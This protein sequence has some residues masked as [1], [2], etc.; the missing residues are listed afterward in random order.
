LPGARAVASIDQLPLTGPG[1]SGT[2]TIAGDAQGA[3]HEVLV[4]SVSDRYFD[5]LGLAVTQGR[6]FEATDGPTSPRVVVV[7]RLLAD[8]IFG[9][10]AV[11]HRIAF[12]FFDGQPWWEIVGVVGNEQ[13][14]ALDRAMQPVVYFPYAQTPGGAFSVVLR[15]DAD[16]VLMEPRVRAAVADL[17]AGTPVFLVRPLVRF[18]EESDAVFRRRTALTVI[19]GFALAALA[20]A[21]VGVY[22][23]VALMVARRTREIGIR[24]ALGATRGQVLL[25]TLRRGLA[26]AAIGIGL[27][28]GASLAAAPTLRSLVFGIGATDGLSLAGAVVFLF[29]VALVAACVPARRVLRIDPVRAL[30]D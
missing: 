1:N 12:P 30:R 21:A 25:G 4:R 23:A 18:V 7:N 17:D 13:F 15:A 2:L 24:Q 8:T 28:V 6:Q 9:G 19:A 11:G 16:P 14:D 5:L 10:D 22:G 20:L 3:R 26:P 27:G 29:V